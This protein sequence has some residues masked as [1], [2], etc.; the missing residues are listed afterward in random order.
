MIDK[1]HRFHGHRSLDY[2]YRR[3]QTARSNFMSLRF[4]PSKNKGHR[5]AVVVSKK[6]DKS[7][8]VRNRIRRR[9]YESVRKIDKE[10][11]LPN[12]DMIISVYDERVAE[13]AAAKLH[14]TIK[15]LIEE[16]V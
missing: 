9:V 2:T 8:V 1:S 10:V 3:G 11:G 14:Q 6:V 15:G 4:A 5:V 7:A 12:K 13:M 16:S